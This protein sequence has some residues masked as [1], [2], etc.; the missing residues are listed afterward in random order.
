MILRPFTTSRPDRYSRLLPP[1]QHSGDQATLSARLR[2]LAEST[3][4]RD[5]EAHDPRLDTPN[6]RRPTQRENVPAGYTYFGQ[7]IMHDLSFDETPLRAAGLREPEQTINY[8]SPRFDL[9]SIYGEGPGSADDGRLYD[10]VRFRLGEAR[11]RAG[12]LFDVPIIDGEAAV[13][14]PRN[15]ENAIVRQ[16]H[17]MLLMLH[18]VAVDELRGSLADEQLFAAARAR[19]RW[20]FQWLVRNDFLPRVCDER[21]YRAIRRGSRLI[22]W[23]PAHFSI[24][25]E[26]AHAAARFG[27][28]LAR[29]TYRLRDRENPVFLRQLF[30]SDPPEPLPSHFAVDWRRFTR[31]RGELARELNT[32]LIATL[33][34][35]P[36]DRFHLYAASAEPDAPRS[37]AERTLARGAAMKLPTGQ[38]MRVA[39]GVPDGIRDDH[40]AWET[41]REYGFEHETPLWYYILLEGEAH[42]AGRGLG[43]VGSR[44]VAEVIDA[45]LRHDGESFLHLRGGEWTPPPWRT[46]KG[47]LIRLQ[48][49]HHLAIVVGLA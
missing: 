18:N 16:I 24:P 25:V 17:A 47:E 1:F 30:G 20:Q 45:A 14:D 21:V 6:Q 28:S 7:F 22:A 48:N 4:E 10:G 3:R 43:L 2:G 46:P 41:L 12:A 49:L 36:N 15:C 9:D 23:P 38:Q 44:I 42:E 32:E 13:A 27:H 37:L 33:F 35:L 11:T 8:K 5:G 19:V 26:F 39:L 31:P 40:P 34:Q 29:N